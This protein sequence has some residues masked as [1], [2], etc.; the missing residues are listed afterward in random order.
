[1]A[2]NNSRL[3]ATLSIP[4]SRQQ[5]FKI[6]FSNGVSVRTG[7]DFT[8]VAVGWQWLHFRR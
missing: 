6:A 7:T 5:S 3:G 8:T 1:M 2:V 4:A